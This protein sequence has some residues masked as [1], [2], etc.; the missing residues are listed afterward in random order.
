MSKRSRKE[1]LLPQ[2]RVLWA[3]GLTKAEVARA[4]SVSLRTIRRWAKQDR[5]AGNP[6]RRGS[7]LAPEPEPAEDELPLVSGSSEDDLVERI[8][9]KL[10]ERLVKLVESDEEESDPKR[11]ED[12]MLKICRVLKELREDRD[13]IGQQIDAVHSFGAYCLR[14]LSEDEM[15]H[16]RRAIRLF[17]DDLKR[18]NS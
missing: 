16:V 13:V 8:Y 15:Q 11:L 5:D 7:E 9:T 12:R 14:T 10:Q 2:A 1:E 6:W 17:L 4:L 3:E 18:E